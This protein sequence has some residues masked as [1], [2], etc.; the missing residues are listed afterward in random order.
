LDA[1]QSIDCSERRM[2]VSGAPIFD[3]LPTP[4]AVQAYQCQCL[5]ERE[6][7]GRGVIALYETWRRFI[8]G[9][10]ISLYLRHGRPHPS[11]NGLLFSAAE[12]ARLPSAVMSG[13]LYQLRV[14]ESLSGTP[15]GRAVHDLLGLALGDR[16]ENLVT[17]LD[18]YVR[19]VHHGLSSLAEDHHRFQ[20]LHELLAA[21]AQLTRRGKFYGT[22]G[23]AIWQFMSRNPSLADQSPVSSGDADVWLSWED[24]TSLELSAFFAVSGEPP[25][26]T[27]SDQEKFAKQLSPA[28]CSEESP[29]LAM[30]YSRYRAEMRGEFEIPAR[31][32]ECAPP[33]VQPILHSLLQTCQ[34][35]KPVLILRHR[36]CE[37]AAEWIERALQTQERL[38]LYYP[39][40]FSPVTLHPKALLSWLWRQLTQAAA[41]DAV[42]DVVLPKDSKRIWAQLGDLMERLQPR[43]PRPIV[44]VDHLEK[45]IGQQAFLQQ[46]TELQKLGLG[47]LALGEPVRLDLTAGW[48]T[49]Y[50]KPEWFPDLESQLITIDVRSWLDDLAPAGTLERQLLECTA[51]SKKP[52]RVQTLAAVLNKSSPEVFCASLR[53]AT[54]FGCPRGLRDLAEGFEELQL[55]CPIIAEA[56]RLGEPQSREIQ[57]NIESTLASVAQANASRRLFRERTIPPPP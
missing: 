31:I 17:A 24:G 30:L 56:I 37:V 19:H 11:I 38:C 13:L 6:S 33:M 12:D 50:W 34:M 35:A 53:L 49:A 32:Q 39:L 10:A 47:V 28:L 18:Q 16:Q 40:A 27:L 21:T 4:L 54:L 46:L 9:L 41:G 57:R 42:V 23:G 29:A 20:Q 44:V 22:T 51:A 15:I 5:T 48:H 26:L 14:R 25:E 7:L 8:F 36:G 43:A 3:E 55:Y 1:V 2:Q 52:F 45:A